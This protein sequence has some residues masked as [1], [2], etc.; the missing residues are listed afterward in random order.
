MKTA[1]HVGA[2]EVRRRPEPRIA[3]R[4]AFD[5]DGVIRAGL[6]R[7]VEHDRRVGDKFSI[8]EHGPRAHGNGPR[9]GDDKRRYGRIGLDQR[10]LALRLV[11]RLGGRAHGMLRCCAG[12]EGSAG[13]IADD[14][15]ETAAVRIAAR[16]AA[17]A[18]SVAMTRSAMVGHSRG[19]A[20][21]MS[22]PISTRWPM[23]LSWSA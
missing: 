7:G 22:K 3:Q 6:E 1:E 18:A 5:D 19:P 13:R 20:S 12:A 16:S 4:A 21:A 10:G 8:A 17:I 15:G 2:A 9:T 23:L 11:G 14:A